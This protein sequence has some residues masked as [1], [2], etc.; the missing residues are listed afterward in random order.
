MKHKTTASRDAIFE[1][2]LAAQCAEGLALARASDILTLVP[3]PTGDGPPQQY[4]AHFECKL[5][6]QEP[7]GSIAERVGFDVGI[8]FPD[9]YLAA[10]NPIQIVTWLGPWEVFHPHVRPPL[11]CLGRLGSGTS[12][13]DILYQVFE[14]VTYQNWAPHDALCLEAAQWARNNAS[15][16][17]L[18]RRSL[19]LRAP[20][21]SSTKAVS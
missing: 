2:F 17:P 8:R 18:E 15:R 6:V 19:K 11:F 7:D 9:D 1:L 20:A 10:I 5:L 3:L 4:L 21:S 14:I 16:F 12:L 13:T